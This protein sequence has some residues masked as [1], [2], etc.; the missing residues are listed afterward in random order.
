MAEAATRL[1]QKILRENPGLN[2]DNIDGA[3]PVAVSA[4]GTW[5]K[6]GYMS[7]YGVVLVLAVETGEVLD[8]EVL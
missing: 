8:F 7:E 3:V 1:Q 5:H 4:D 2:R 6:G